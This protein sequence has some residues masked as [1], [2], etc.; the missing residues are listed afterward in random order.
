MA[1]YY[2][3]YYVTMV[4]IGYQRVLRHNSLLLSKG[5]AS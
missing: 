2:N 3:G 1:Y 5:I 4:S